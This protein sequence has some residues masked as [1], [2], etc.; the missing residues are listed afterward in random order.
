MKKLRIYMLYFFS[1]KLSTITLAIKQSTERTQPLYSY[2]L[3]LLSQ[4]LK[5]NPLCISLYHNNQPVKQ[6]V[7]Y[8]YYEYDS[9]L[10]IARVL[11]SPKIF[12][13]SFSGSL[14]GKKVTI[15]ISVVH[16]RI[17]KLKFIP[18]SWNIQQVKKLLSSKIKEPVNS[19][20]FYFL[21]TPVKDSY[22][23]VDLIFQ[24]KLLLDP[25]TIKKKKTT[26]DGE[27]LSK[28]LTFF[29]VQRK[30]NEHLTFQNAPSTDTFK[31]STL[32]AIFIPIHKNG[33]RKMGL[34]ILKMCTNSK[35][36][37]KLGG[38]LIGLPIHL[39]DYCSKNPPE[40]IAK[41]CL[42]CDRPLE[43]IGFAFYN[44]WFK[45]TAKRYS[46]LLK[47]NQNNTVNRTKHKNTNKNKNNKNKNNK[48]KNNN[49][50]K[51]KNNKNSPNSQNN[52]IN[53]QS[54]YNYHFLSK[55]WTRV[56]N[57]YLYSYP[58]VN[59]FFSYFDWFKIQV[60]LRN[61]L[62]SSCNLCFSLLSHRQDLVK[63]ECG[64]RFHSQCLHKSK[65]T[66]KCVICNNAL[67]EDFSDLIKNS[68]SKPINSNVFNINKNFLI[69]KRLCNN[70]SFS[71]LI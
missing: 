49:K 51:N 17:I 32:P 38:I 30:F 60:S 28:Q 59:R 3:P 43:N 42:E 40:F 23:V 69:E 35:A 48:S 16:K 34:T 5:V 4:I 39:N 6:N 19:Q 8:E 14:F 65:Y 9:G 24:K 27:N 21:G 46:T 57:K 61:P 29:Y 7:K 15:T 18:I 63:F 44:C 54:N 53:S 55:N 66:E 10:L 50:N 20:I 56:E 70:L 13:Q 52:Q 45:C 58:R 11:N 36:N 26:S 25:K 68:K 22:R 2:L 64:H 33:M 47:K 67:T 62:L 37:C 1:P 41:N 31:N 12:K 71:Q